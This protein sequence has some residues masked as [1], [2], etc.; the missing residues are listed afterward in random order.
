MAA[1]Q[2]CRARR[3]FSASERS[4][5]NLGGNAQRTSHKFN[6]A[7]LEAMWE[8]FNREG[9]K[10][11]AGVARP[12]R[13]LSQGLRDVSAEGTQGGASGGIKAMIDEQLDA[14]LDAFIARAPGASAPP[15]PRT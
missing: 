4:C 10:V 7:F 5:G 15:R 1:L 12:A 13:D 3:F 11:I 2:G 9:R 8:R 14:A 6:K